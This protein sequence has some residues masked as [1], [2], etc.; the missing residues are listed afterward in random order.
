MSEQPR[1]IMVEV[2][3]QEYNKIISGGL[4]NS[5]QE[6]STDQ[7]FSELLRRANVNIDAVQHGSTE[8]KKFIC[9]D[10]R[11]IIDI[12]VKDIAHSGW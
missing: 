7:L 5:I 2:T 11:L 8:Y 6:F 3:P 12:S 4:N 9:G 1:K 10:L